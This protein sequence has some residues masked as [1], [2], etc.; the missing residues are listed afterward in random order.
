MVSISGMMYTI[1]TRGK[2]HLFEGNF[3]LATITQMIFGLSI[4]FSQRI[5]KLPTHTKLD[6][7]IWVDTANNVRGMYFMIRFLKF[8]SSRYWES[9]HFCNHMPY[10][11]TKNYHTN[12]FLNIHTH[13]HKLTIQKT[14]RL[15][16]NLHLFIYNWPLV[17]TNPNQQMSPPQHRCPPGVK[18]ASETAAPG[19]NSKGTSWKAA[20]PTKSAAKVAS[21]AKRTLTSVEMDGFW[22]TL[23]WKQGIFF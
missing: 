20:L 23:R 21:S 12:I 22:K 13:T 9:T 15:H 19:I 8:Q 6:P 7:Y 10:D 14:P 4:F 5:G 11:I 2:T 18:T 16:T 1:E 17:T 3:T